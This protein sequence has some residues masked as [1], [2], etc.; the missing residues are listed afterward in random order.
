MAIV[1]LWVC[2]ILFAGNIGCTEK[3]VSQHPLPRPVKVLDSAAELSLLESLGDWVYDRP[4]EIVQFPDTIFIRYPNLPQTQEG[5]ELYVWLMINIA[6]SLRE[7]G[8][9]IESARYYE[10]ALLHSNNWN[11]EEPAIV[12]YILKPLGNV[13]TQ[14]GDLQKAETI[15]LRA[16]QH[17]KKSHSSVETA[18]VLGNLAIVYRFMNKPDIALQT[19][20]E[21]VTFT[22]RG[23]RLGL[24][25]NQISECHSAIGHIDSAKFYN[26]LAL[27]ELQIHPPDKGN[28]SWIASSLGQAAALSAVDNHKDVALQNADTALQLL[29]QYY[30]TSHQR[31]KA[32]LY[33][34][35]GKILQT[36]IDSARADLH[37][38]LA[39]MQDIRKNSKDD[40]YL[41]TE[42][43]WNLARSY[44][45]SNHLDSAATYYLQAVESSFNSQQNISSKV[46]SFQNS[47]W[48]R[49]LLVEAM[50]AFYSLSRRGTSYFDQQT[51]YWKM[52]WIT[53]L[54][55]G[56]QLLQELQRKEK[57]QLDSISEMQRAEFIQDTLLPLPIEENE[58]LSKIEQSDSVGKEIAAR[59]VRF[60]IDFAQFQKFVAEQ[61]YHEPLI[62]YLL[63]EEGPMA[64]MFVENG[65]ILVN[66]I[67][68]ATEVRTSL[69][70]FTN[71]YFLNGPGAYEN[72]PNDYIQHCS[73]L[74]H[75][76]IPFHDS[77]S[78]PE[79][80]IS[81]D[82]E[83]FSLPFEA[84]QTSKG[85]WCEEKHI[86]Y[87][88]TAIFDL[89]Q[90][91]GNS[92]QT[93]IV[94]LFREKYND[95][96]P[97]LPF[98]QKEASI[99]K[100]KFGGS[101]YQ[102]R[103]N[104]DSIFYM[105][106]QTPEI[107]HVAAH[108]IVS[109]SR[110][111][112]LAFPKSVTLNSLDSMPAK[113]PLVVLSACRSASG[114]VVP[115]EGLESLNKALL[116]TGVKGV[117]GAQWSVDDAAMPRL[118]DLYYSSLEQSG[119]TAEALTE[120]KRAFLQESKGYLRNP[121]YWATLQFTGV[122]SQIT[123]RSAQPSLPEGV[124]VWFGIL[125][126]LTI[127]V[128]L[129]RFIGK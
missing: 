82:N 120:A 53:E 89:M 66:I 32:K 29:V 76:L 57:G 107:I 110:E 88:P 39:L 77:I 52:L 38:G 5:K 69:N 128:Y 6:Y 80:V 123:L 46:S 27:K 106:L 99:I 74:I 59:H 33:L 111:A 10:R 36:A 18:S 24:L 26:A 83:L 12:P 17:L 121:W 67:E 79:V 21:A 68:D 104:L 70:G 81:P 51:N 94:G 1:R 2:I 101:V 16:I 124:A 100:K 113:S 44:S 75:Q 49:Q 103:A 109:E 84:L 78:S 71:R 41:I 62:S 119:R 47:H 127:A 22:E 31:E 87:T 105:A 116:R 60:K 72:N 73:Q 112:F 37:K 50:N 3:P 20:R 86:R 85:F 64:V 11:L 19:C 40:D 48:S 23:P 30:P 129:Y 114:P 54:S 92:S 96:L 7:Y 9:V 8:Q 115:A 56:R 25:W 28:L 108:A 13:Y 43:L 4:E 95:T 91:A 125:L 34:L 98:V 42:L 55:K 93:G 118:I 117:I 15:H 90:T 35:R 122:E 61:S 14:I 45:D 126:F 102:E 63:P 97:D 65:K 58:S